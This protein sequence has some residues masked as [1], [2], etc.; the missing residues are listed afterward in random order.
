ML[1]IFANESRK[2]RDALHARRE[3]FNGN[4]L[5]RNGKVDSLI[6]PG[7]LLSVSLSRRIRWNRLEKGKPRVAHLCHFT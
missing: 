2:R 6:F 4:K 3:I 7:M 5:S 1:I